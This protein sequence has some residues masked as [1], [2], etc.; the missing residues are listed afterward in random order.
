MSILIVDDTPNNLLT[1]QYILNLGGYHDIIAL[2]CATKAYQVLGVDKPTHKSD[3]DLILMDMIMPDIDG[4][5]ATQF[6]NNQSHLSDIPIIMV[7]VEDNVNQLQKAFDAGVM[8]F[9]RKPIEETEILARV[10]ALLKLK[11]ERDN[12]K[13][14]ELELKKMT[15]QLENALKEAEAANKAKTLFLANMS[16]EIRTPMNAVIGMTDLALQ[17]EISDKVKNYLLKVKNAANSLLAII[18]DILDLSKIEADQMVFESKAFNLH[19]VMDE[20]ADMFAIQASEK[21]LELVL[22]TSMDI[23]LLILGDPLRIRQILINLISNAIKFTNQGEI[24]IYTTLN[25][26]SNEQIWLEF[27]VKDTGIGLSKEQIPHLFKPFSQADASTSRNFGGTGLGLSICKKLVEKMHGSI[28]VKSKEAE[29]STFIFTIQCQRHPDQ[30]DELT[31]LPSVDHFRILIIEEHETARKYLESL[32]MFNHITVTSFSSGVKA[33]DYLNQ[34]SE[35][36]NLIII[37]R[38]IKSSNG[39]D[40]AKSIHNLPNYSHVPIIAL[41]PFGKESDRIKAEI[42]GISAF[43]YKPVKRIDVYKKIEQLFNDSNDQPDDTPNDSQLDKLKTKTQKVFIGKKALVVEDN[44]INA[45]IILEHLIL[46]GF[47]TIHAKDGNEAIELTAQ[48]LSNNSPFDIIIM[49]IEM[50]GMDGFQ[51]TKK[52]R[53]LEKEY[54]RKKNIPIIAMTAHAM[55]E[56]KQ[57]CLDAGMNNYLS[58]PFEPEDLFNQLKD[59]FSNSSQNNH[60]LNNQNEQEQYSL[61]DYTNVFD[62]KK[63]LKKISGNKQLLANLCELF[64]T[65]Y[66]DHFISI[67]DGYKPQQLDDLFKFVHSLKGIAQNLCAYKLEYTCFHLEKKINDNDTEYINMLLSELDNN[68]KELVKTF[69]EV[70]GEPN[71]SIN[72]LTDQVHNP[73][74]STDKLTMVLDINTALK[75]MSGNRKL[76]ISLMKKFISDYSNVLEGIKKNIDNKHFEEAKRKVHS[77][78]GI[79]GNFSANQLFNASRELE[80]LLLSQNLDDIVAFLPHLETQL[81]AVRNAML[82]ILQN[83]SEF[84]D[85]TSLKNQLKHILRKLYYLL[86]EH[87]IESLEIKELFYQMDQ[88]IFSQYD[89]NNELASLINEI[90]AYQFDHAFDS[91]IQLSNKI[92]IDLLG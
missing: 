92:G 35:T 51:A 55:L 91:L 84:L 19:S 56:V 25:K 79:A 83:E 21:N 63:A 61:L 58:K 16:H 26:K 89:C 60:V 8:D 76:F 7:T 18:N 72:N 74:N 12:R 36:Y 67:L 32:F 23:P 68:I 86:K 90:E 80:V 43:V 73:K 45:Q 47:I 42:A 64:V 59:I 54:D 39:F 70:I 22:H 1:L 33:I 15:Q 41:I 88:S 14:R 24:S 17:S 48:T 40:T 20:L 85:N 77:I 44:D 9:I 53:I 30:I 62:Q 75:R 71:F 87:D 31:L 50:P 46:K 28:Q 10:G 57:K 65:E 6:I 4:I 13:A 38:K 11:E 82:H 37:D 66:K 3:I 52:I 78:K 69:E 5:E 29:G 27:T 2:D 34:S 49:D 81:I